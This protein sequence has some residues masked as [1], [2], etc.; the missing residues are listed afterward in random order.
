MTTCDTRADLNTAATSVAELVEQLPGFLDILDLLG[1]AIYSLNMAMQLGFT[2]RAGELKPNYSEN[3]AKRM[4]AIS[5]GRIPQ[6]GL[7][8]A[9]LHFNSAIFRIAAAYRRC[10][11]AFKRRERRLGTAQPTRFETASL[12]RIRDECDR[13]KHEFEGILRGRLAVA[14]LAIT[15]L[16]ELIRA[17]QARRD[18]LV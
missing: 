3:L 14:E 13:L 18:R 12:N 16:E 10:Q 6:S 11:D 17:L 7:W 4:R 5:A 8:L 2:D 15:A 9:G 1:G